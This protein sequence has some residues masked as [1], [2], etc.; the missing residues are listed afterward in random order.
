MSI[1]SMLKFQDENAYLFSATRWA[2]ERMEY[3]EPIEN[4]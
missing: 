3:E 4:T 2:T 1:K